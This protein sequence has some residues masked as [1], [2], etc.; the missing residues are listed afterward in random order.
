MDLRVALVWE[1]NKL[2]KKSF[3]R[4]AVKFKYILSLVSVHVDPGQE[5]IKHPSWAVKRFEIPFATVAF[6]DSRAKSDSN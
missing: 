2:I 1:E 5:S 6:Y 4:A 3:Y